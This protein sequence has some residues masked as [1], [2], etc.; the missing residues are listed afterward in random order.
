MKSKVIMG[1]EG[2]IEKY[3][4]LHRNIDFIKED[5]KEYIQSKKFYRVKMDL[6]N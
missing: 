3:E 2:D 6:V 1:Q 5:I 4:K